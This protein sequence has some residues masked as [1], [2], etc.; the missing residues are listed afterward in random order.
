MNSEKIPHSDLPAHVAVIMDGNGRWAKKR[1]MN[2]IRGHEK[3]AGTVRMAVRVCREIGIR[4]LTLYAFSTENWARPKAEVD[5]LMALLGKFVRSEQKEM[6]EKRI[7]L[8]V[9]GQ[10]GRLPEWVRKRIHEALELTKGGDA[11]TLTIALSYGGRD[12]LVSMAREIARK[13]ADGRL[14]P[15]SITAET[16]AGHLQTADMP[17]PDLLIR[18][19]GEMRVSNFL[20][21]QIAYSEIFVT[22]TLWPDFSE[23]ELRGIL[24]DYRLRERRFGK[25]P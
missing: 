14:S 10:T 21:W 2:R 18:T 5:A 20:L 24:S 1:M 19:S 17:D 11:M 3:G 15:E 6:A 13:A 16:V 12:E 8:N 4:Y 22:P 9:I 25:T 7:R 23:E